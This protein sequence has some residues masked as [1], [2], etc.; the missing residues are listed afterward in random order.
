MT[1][2]LVTALAFTVWLL[3]LPSSAASEEVGQC[4]KVCA[5]RLGS[6]NRGAAERRLA[7]SEACAMPHQNLVVCKQECNDAHQSAR[8]Q[9]FDAYKDCTPV[10]SALPTRTPTPRGTATIT[11]T[12]TPTGSPSPKP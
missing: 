5:V 10:C 12:W 9:C 1:S 3:S 8:R 7:C 11:A 6:C 2:R 4:V